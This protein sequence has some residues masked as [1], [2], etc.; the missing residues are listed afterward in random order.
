MAN[1]INFSV[2]FQA[3][4]NSYNEL[5]SMLKQLQNFS[6][7][8]VINMG[9]EDAAKT[10]I[11]IKTAAS[12]VENALKRAYN[13][14]LSTVNIEKFNAELADSQYTL[15]EVQTNFQKAGA[16]GENAFRKLS[17]QILSTNSN[18]K[19]SHKWL[20][21]IAETFTNTVKWNIASSVVNKFTGSI[22]QAYGYV[23]SL[24]TSLNNIRIVTGYSAEQM[25]DFAIEANNA[26]KALGQNTTAYTEAALI[27]YQQG[28]PED[29]VKTLADITLK[30]AN[31]T[32][33]ST[34][35]VSELLTAVWNGYKVDAQEAELYVDKLAAVAA[36][37][38]SDLEEL[39]IGMSKVA[40]AAGSM[41]IDVDQL[42]AMLSTIISVT[43]QAPESVGTAL[44][45]IFARM[46]DLELSGV[47]EE[48]V[49]LGDV[50][51]SLDS[52]GIKILDTTGNL[53]DMGVVIEEVGQKWNSGVWSDAE[54]QA[55][56]ID[57]AGKRSLVLA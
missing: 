16:A 22:E 11:E 3:D 45:T 1:K 14:K 33:Q 44:K 46:G 35:E 23:K 49:T 52:V 42:N 53:R 28:L 25:A 51:E 50:S 38:A 6:K 32:G 13:Q 29:Q 54:K 19:E 56:A 9:G 24:D 36:A 7:E 20:D 57:L 43:R 26:A 8:N 40:S 30:T 41:G 34:D 4:K 48:G 37:T 5:L 31:V 10:L 12:A 17:T 47:D 21:E 39:S 2:G 27:Y 18:L 55:L 15:Q